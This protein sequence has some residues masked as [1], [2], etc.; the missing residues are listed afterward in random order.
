VRVLFPLVDARWAPEIADE[1]ACPIGGTETLVVVEDEIGVRKYVC[2]VLE[3]HGYRVLDASR[4]DDAIEIARRY[5]GPID[6]LL[7]D[8]VLPGMSGADV[9]RRFREIRPG[10]PVL[11]MSGYPERFGAQLSDG[12]P[13]L[14][15]PFTADVLL[16]RLRKIFDAGRGASAG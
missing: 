8:V 7:T 5:G 13:L 3:S 10:V 9:V 16:N 6:L 11:R 1:P 14:Q 4:G 15:K 2:K 12:V